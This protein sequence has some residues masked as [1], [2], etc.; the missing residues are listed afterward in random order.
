M[1]PNM[2]SKVAVITGGAGMIGYAAAHSLARA[3]ANLMLVDINAEGLGERRRMLEALG[4]RVETCVADVSRSSDV[5][6]YVEQ[7]ITAFGRIDAFFNNAGIE[8]KLGSIE[9][10]DE[11]EFDR[12]IAVNLR[13]IFLGLRHVLPV[14]ALSTIRH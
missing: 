14:S 1:I 3:G 2:N 10:Y 4:A 8:G 7:T 9:G 6:A 5:A 13:G 11:A 12:I